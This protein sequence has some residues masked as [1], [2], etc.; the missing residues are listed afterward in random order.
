VLDVWL[1][2]GSE[3]R[4]TWL[5]EIAAQLSPE[6][7]ERLQVFIRRYGGQ[8]PSDIRHL[9]NVADMREMREILGLPQET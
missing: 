1:D 2:D 7:Q 5:E 8:L 3:G 6:R 4:M 9:R